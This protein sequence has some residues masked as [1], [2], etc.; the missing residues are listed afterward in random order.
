MDSQYFDT[1]MVTLNGTHL[2]VIPILT[3]T[4]IVEAKL[5]GV[6]DK[7][8]NKVALNVPLVAKA[9]LII[10]TPVVVSPHILS[11]PWDPRSKSR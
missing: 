10:N 2:V 9:E 1:Q 7:N 4:T 5:H 11:V 6:V 8:G 3:G